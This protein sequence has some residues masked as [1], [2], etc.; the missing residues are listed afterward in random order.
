[1]S[2]S[3][4][5]IGIASDGSVQIYQPPNVTAF[6]P[7]DPGYDVRYGNPQVLADGQQMTAA[8]NPTVQIMSGTLESVGL[9]QYRLVTIVPR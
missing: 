1:M 5:A 4:G 2:I 7:S 6:V 8:G 9:T 3:T